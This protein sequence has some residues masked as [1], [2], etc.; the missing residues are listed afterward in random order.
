MAVMPP[1][2]LK[3]LVV[4]VFLAQATE[5]RAATTQKLAFGQKWLRILHY[6]KQGDGYESRVDNPKFFV[7]TSANQTL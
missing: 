1:I 6:E 3:Y 7:S 4:I 5:S 2:I